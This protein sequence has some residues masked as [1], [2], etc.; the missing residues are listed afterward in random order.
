MAYCVNCGVELGE[1]EKACPLCN[2]KVCHPKYHP[3]PGA[4]PYPRH[5][6][7]SDQRVSRSGIILIITLIFLLPTSIVAMADVSINYKITWSG[8]ALGAFALLYIALVP[9]LASK[10]QRPVFF[11]VLDAV[12]LGLYLLYIEKITGGIWFSS[13][14]LYIIAGITTAVAILLSLARR[15]KLLGLRLFAFSLFSAALLPVLIEWRINAAFGLRG[16]LSWSLY[17]FIVN[18]ILGA[19]CLVINKNEPL[20]EKLARKF[21]L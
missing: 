7:I 6:S 12:C 1:S 18:I 19:I 3:N 8:Y 10:K 5:K 17:P 21:F 4:A 9:P 2:T 11:I 16:F 20:K 15:K 14:A 13:L